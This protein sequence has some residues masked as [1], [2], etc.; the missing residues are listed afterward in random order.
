MAQVVESACHAGDTEHRSV[1]PESGRRKQQPIPVFL[2]GKS[3]GQRDLADSSPWGHKESDV[4]EC[5]CTIYI[6]FAIPRTHGSVCQSRA[7]AYLSPGPRRH[8]PSY[9]QVSGDA[10][11][12]C[13]LNSGTLLSC[14]HSLV[15]SYV[16]SFNIYLWTTWWAVTMPRES[17]RA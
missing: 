3:H 17:L 13:R 6:L 4:T 5:A 1:I 2:P 15:P 14:L 11:H 12:L 7:F 9:R 16:Y 8:F 10:V